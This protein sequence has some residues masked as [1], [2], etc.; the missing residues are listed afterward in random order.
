MDYK[1]LFILIEG[2]DD[3]RFFESVVKPFIQ[4][5][6]SAIK[7]WQYAKENEMRKVNFIKS[8]NSMKADY[9][10]VGDI[11]NVPCVTFKKEKITDG[12]GKKIT[13]DRIVIVIRAIESWYLAGLDEKAAKK[14]HI[15]KKIETTDNVIKKH[16]NQLIPKNMPRPV[17][18]QKI[19]ENYDVEIAKGK[20]RSFGYFLTKWMND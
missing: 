9:I 18:M 20:N 10:C 17:F 13:A 2:D 11:D 6:Y 15:R 1:L 7:F 16:F 19:L 12:F 3:E 8:I 4:E 5:R 14:L